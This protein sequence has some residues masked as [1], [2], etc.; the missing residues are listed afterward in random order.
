M[1]Q[2]RVVAADCRSAR[3]PDLSQEAWEAVAVGRVVGNRSRVHRADGANSGS[4][5]GRHAGTKQVRNSNSRDDQNNRDHDQQLNQRKTL[6]FLNH[7]FLLGAVLRIFNV[8]T[9][10]RGTA[11]YF[12]RILPNWEPPFTYGTHRIIHHRF[13]RMRRRSGRDG[14]SSGSGFGWEVGN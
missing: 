3:G 6:L 10:W 11:N 5:V 4:F 8:G 1:Q 9:P 7:S 13:N 12:A 14:G 2:L